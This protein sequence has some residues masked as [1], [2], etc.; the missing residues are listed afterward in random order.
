MKYSRPVLAQ[1]SI[2]IKKKTNK[3]TDFSI[4]IIEC[5]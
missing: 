1:Q 2:F 3:K 4:P 5:M